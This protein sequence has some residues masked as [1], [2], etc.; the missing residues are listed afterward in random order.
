[1]LR[2]LRLRLPL[3]HVLLLLIMPLLQLLGLLL[4]TLLY[5]LRSRIISPLLSQALVI[6]LLFLLKPLPVL[7]LP[8]IHLV[9]LLLVFLIYLRIS[10]VRCRWP[11]V[12]R[13]FVHVNW[14]PIGIGGP[15]IVAAARDSIVACA[16]VVSSNVVGVAIR[17]RR[18]F[19]TS[20]CLPGW[21]DAA[22][23]ECGWPWSSCDR[24][25]TLIHRGAQI[26]ISA[27]R[28][29]VLH[30]RRYWRQVPLTR[31]SFLLPRWA[32]IDAAISAVVTD[33]INGPI[34]VY[35]R[36]VV[37]VVNFGDIDVVYGTVVVEA[38][39][40]PSS[41]FIPMPEIS[42][43]IVDAAVKSNLRAPVAFVKDEGISAPGPIARRP[44]I[45]DFGRLHPCARHPVIVA[46][47][48]IPRPIPRCPEVAFGGAYGLFVH[49][50]RRWRKSHRNADTHL[51]KRRP[52]SGKQK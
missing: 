15:N 36:G 42:I 52:G 19:V 1:V 50:Q 21:H 32:L 7:L 27:R 25:L 39:A 14:R 51:R 31:S 16:A 11:L 3:L 10:G 49:R 41:A 12:R 8:G 35:D 40:V 34:V 20:A 29:H 48:V 33:A 23:V 38:I 22:L 18:R 4:M 24:R 47:L 46:V 9:L 13:K 17:L 43:S 5:L 45:A 28:L 6:L 37:G 2:L 30:L 44:Q 26:P